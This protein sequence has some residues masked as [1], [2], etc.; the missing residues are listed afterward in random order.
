MKA[1]QRLSAITRPQCALWLLHA[2]GPCEARMLKIIDVS[3]VLH[4]MRK[5]PSMSYMSYMSDV[6]NLSM[7]DISYIVELKEYKIIF[8]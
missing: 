8:S 7:S 6:E 5:K 1:A 3:H 4:E 2:V